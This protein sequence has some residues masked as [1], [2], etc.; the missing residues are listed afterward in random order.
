MTQLYR[1]YGNWPTAEFKGMSS[2]DQMAFMREIG[3][4][5]TINDIKVS[6]NELFNRFVKLEDN[7]SEGGAYLPLTVWATKGFNIDNIERLSLAGDVKEHPVLGTV[8]RVRILTVGRNGSRGW[9]RDS[10]FQSARVIQRPPKRART[11]ALPAPPAEAA[12]GAEG[13]AGAEPEADEDGDDDSSDG[14]SSSSSSSSSASK[15]KSKKKKAKK[16][17]KAKKKDKK[18]KKKEAEKAKAEK[19]KKK[20]EDK[21]VKAEAKKVLRARPACEPTSMGDHAKWTI[22]RS[23]TEDQD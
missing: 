23:A 2:A 22:N 20:E 14:S 13:A 8:Y 9:T 1:A 17:K 3:A 19:E 11:E 7:F 12:E 15:K 16:A 4:K 5:N 10:S 21:K 18:K 6:A